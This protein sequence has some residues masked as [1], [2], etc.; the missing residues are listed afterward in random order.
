[1]YGLLMGLPG[2]H[3]SRVDDNELPQLLFADN[4]SCF[5]PG[6]A[7]CVGNGAGHMNA[8]PAPV[9]SPS[10]RLPSAYLSVSVT[11]RDFPYHVLNPPKIYPCR[12]TSA[13][14]GY[15]IGR[16]LHPSREAYGLT[17][18]SSCRG[19]A[20]LR[21]ALSYFRCRRRRCCSHRADSL[22]FVACRGGTA[23]ADLT[24][25]SPPFSWAVDRGNSHCE[26]SAA[27]PFL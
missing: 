21:G 22:F 17:T 16:R 18:C 15:S 2:V 5:G 12:S 27:P 20:T 24:E 9:T 14:R 4:R 10:R 23:S 1:M 3:S 7:L 13:L 26:R 8:T 11:V 19:H 6:R 25:V